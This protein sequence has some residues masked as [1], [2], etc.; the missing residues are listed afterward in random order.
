[1]AAADIDV[2]HL[3]PH[4][5][6]QGEA[7]PGLAAGEAHAHLIVAVVI[8]GQVHQAYQALGKDLVQGDEKSQRH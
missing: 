4:L 1:M 8:V 6:A 7:G 3:D 5:I 2:G